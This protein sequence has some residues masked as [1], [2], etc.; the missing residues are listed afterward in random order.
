M[1]IGGPELS[2]DLLIGRLVVEVID[3]TSSQPVR[4]W[5]LRLARM[6]RVPY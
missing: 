6:R 4:D 3:Q 2:H 1:K 5:T